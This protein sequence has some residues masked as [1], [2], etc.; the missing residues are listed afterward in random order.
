MAI[1]N[2]LKGKGVVAVQTS[3]ASMLRGAAQRKLEE[4][5]RRK[6]INM[7]KSFCIA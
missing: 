1:K 4:R 3:T 2:K 7:K 5:K 6:G